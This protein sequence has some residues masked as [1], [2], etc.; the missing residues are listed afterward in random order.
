MEGQRYKRR[1]IRMAIADQDSRKRERVRCLGI[2]DII[3]WRRKETHPGETIDPT[4]S[5]WILYSKDRP[6]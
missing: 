2:R 6:H 5:S 3:F 4:D 1:A